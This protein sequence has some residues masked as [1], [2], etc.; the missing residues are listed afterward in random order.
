MP[1]DID[2]FMAVWAVMLGLSGLGTWYEWREGQVGNVDEF[3]RVWFDTFS[4]WSGAC[5]LFGLAVYLLEWLGR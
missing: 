3:F 2:R 1:V 4:K 5:L